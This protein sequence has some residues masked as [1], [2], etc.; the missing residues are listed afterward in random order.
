MPA[1]PGFQS[2]LPSGPTYRRAPYAA[3]PKAGR[4]RRIPE[5]QS[6]T[7]TDFQRDRDRVLHSTAFRR[8]AN[9]TQVFVLVEGD[10]YR[11][12]LTHTIE[13]GQIARALARALGLDDDLAEALALAHDLGHPPFGHTGEDALAVA[14]ASYGGFD[15]NAQAL[16]IVTSLERRYAAF[17]GLN[18]TWDTLEG[19]VKHNGPLRSATDTAVPPPIAEFDAL[20]PLDLDKFA[21]AEAQAAALADDIAY[22]GHDLDD[23]LRAGLFSLEQVSAVPFIAGILDEVQRVHPQLEESRR[24]H[25]LVRRVITRFVEDAIAESARRLG[26]L[27]PADIGAIRAAA[28]PVVAFSA[29]MQGAVREM[30]TFLFEHMYRAPQVVPARDAATRVVSRLFAKF[31]VEPQ[32]MPSDWGARALAAQSETKRARVVADYIAG[33]TDRYAVTLYRRFFDDPIDLR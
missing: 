13:V 24:I 28:H 6:A 21:S 15:H 8:L 4:G 12:R 22:N 19:L 17:D 20:W 16:R 30:R 3:D 2:V 10:S 9:K 33:M 26:E 32:L 1:N 23:G 14:M 18:L 31:V 25:E 5:P 27:A 29:A 11:T 7:R